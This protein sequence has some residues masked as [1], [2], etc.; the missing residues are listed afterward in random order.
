MILSYLN[1]GVEILCTEWLPAAI[2]TAGWVFDSKRADLQGQDKL[3]TTINEWPDIVYRRFLK[4]GAR[5]VRG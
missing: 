4:R 3:N 2:P 1:L 5:R